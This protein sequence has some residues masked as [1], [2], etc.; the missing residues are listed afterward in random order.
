MAQIGPVLIDGPFF[1]QFHDQFGLGSATLLAIAGVAE[2]LKIVDVVGAAFRLRHNMV[3]GE[4]LERE[5]DA[6]AI[7]EPLLLARKGCACESCKAAVFL[8]QC[9]WG[10][11]RGV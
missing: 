3:D 11:L 7:A 6:A 2:K 5:G 1:P 8:R 10:R 9:A 4:V